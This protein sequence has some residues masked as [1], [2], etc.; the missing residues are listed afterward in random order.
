MRSHRDVLKA[1]NEK[2]L[3]MIEIAR[4]IDFGTQL[5]ICNMV[6]DNPEKFRPHTSNPDEFIEHTRMVKNGTLAARRFLVDALGV[7]D[8]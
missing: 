8:E 6:L 7:E 5:Y 4:S 2:L 1:N 3:Q